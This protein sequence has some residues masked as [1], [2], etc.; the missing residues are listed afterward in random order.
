MA[1]SL[2]K[3]AVLRP[4]F[5]NKA[6][7]CC[8]TSGLYTKVS[9]KKSHKVCLVKSSFVGPNPPVKITK[10]TSLKASLSVFV[11]CSGSSLIDMLFRVSTPTEYNCWLMKVLLVS[12]T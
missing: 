1:C 7:I 4:N 10:S 3:S 9:S 12:I 8:I 2:F 6:S 11:I 5:L